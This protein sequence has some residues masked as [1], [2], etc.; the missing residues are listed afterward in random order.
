MPSR[1]FPFV[2]DEYYHVFNRGVAHMPIFN[3]AWNY[4]RFLKSFIYNQIDNKKP[5]FSWLFGK[6][7]TKSKKKSEIKELKEKILSGA[8]SHKGFPGDQPPIPPTKNKEQKNL[9]VNFD[10]PFKFK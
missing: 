3:S 2:N 9:R 1:A 5:K 6:L 8:E 7:F 4:Q 10:E